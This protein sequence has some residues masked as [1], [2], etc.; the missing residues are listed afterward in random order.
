M[1]ATSI[2]ETERVRYLLS[3]SSPAE[4]EQIESRYFEDEDA[5]EEMMTAE[6]DLIDA[7]VR[8]ELTS[9][10]RQR[11][12]KSFGRS[13]DRNRIRFARAL[14][15]VTSAYPANKDIS[16]HIFK[17]FRAPVV[18]RT[19][20][21]AVVIVFVAVLVWLV[22]D[23]RRMT[24]EVRDLRGDSPELSRRLDAPQQSTNNEPTRTAETGPQ[25]A[26]PQVTR[27]ES[28]HS[29][30]GTIANR[31]AQHLPLVQ[32]IRENFS[33]VITPSNTFE[34]KRITQLPLEAKDIPNLLTLQT[35]NTRGASVPEQ[36]ADQTNL[37][38][39]GIDA[40][41]RNRV[42]LVPRNA[43]NDDEPTLLILSSGTWVRFQL[44]LETAATHEDYRIRIQTPNGRYVTSA[45]WTEPLTA[46]QTVIDTPIIF[47]NDLPSGDYVLVLMG[48]DPTGH[49][50]KLAEYAF[51][52]SR[53]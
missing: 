32:E 20:M 28:R 12:E 31:L 24:Q 27:Y 30:A 52:V 35:A 43:S 16:L 51:K 34:A 3:L 18:L 45:E 19:A 15:D 14:T 29:G 46:N 26:K 38:L 41:F 33:V 7:Y 39:D 49:F 6:D 44:G 22:N 10:E 4:R 11:F 13:L 40:E 1:A 5:F 9:D 23:R 2:S 48:K 21:I 50:V 8:G 36:R 37:S 47:T 25:P 53:Y 42:T 17:F